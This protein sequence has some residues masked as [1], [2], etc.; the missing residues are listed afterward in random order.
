MASV[1][2]GNVPLWMN[3]ARICE[4]L[5]SNFNM[6]DPVDV[7][8]KYKDRCDRRQAYCFID[9]SNKSQ[10]EAFRLRRGTM[11]WPNGKFILVRRTVAHNKRNNIDL[12]RGQLAQRVPQPEPDPCHHGA[13]E[14]PFYKPATGSGQNQRRITC[15]ICRVDRPVTECAACLKPVCD[16]LSCRGDPRP[17]TFRL[18]RSVCAEC[19]DAF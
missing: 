1:W 14:P 13:A 2:L 4:Y 17:R 19:Y 7:R 10:A 15:F 12:C 3:E 5:C 18:G 9:F 11:H 16:N 8:I 6:A